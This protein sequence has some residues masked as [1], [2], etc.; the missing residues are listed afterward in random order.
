MDRGGKREREKEVNKVLGK[1]LVASMWDRFAEYLL[2]IRMG[3]YGTEVDVFAGAG[4]LREGKAFY[5]EQNLHTGAQF[6]HRYRCIAWLG[7]SLQR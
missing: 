2:G 3:W 6:C 4:Y 1:W 5:M 7:I